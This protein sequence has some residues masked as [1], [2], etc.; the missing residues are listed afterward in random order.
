MKIPASTIA[1]AIALYALSAWAQ[2]G[3]GIGPAA[4]P[5]MHNMGSG[6]HASSVADS[7]S[8]R[9][10]TPSQQLA[11][12]T[13]LAGKIQALTGMPA[14][15]ACSGFKNLGQCVAAAHVSKN[16]GISFACLRSDMIGQAPLQGTSCPS[17]TGWKSMSLGKAIQ[18]LHPSADHALEAKKGR[19]EAD[20]DLKET[21]SGS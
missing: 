17:R 5:A 6:R 1:L 20:Q 21:G 18:T 12:N 7:P 2:H 13:R 14:Q 3:Q 15:Q 4:G 10:V 11:R 19:R 16:L 9:G 8:G